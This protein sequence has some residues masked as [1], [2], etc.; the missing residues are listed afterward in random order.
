MCLLFFLESSRFFAILWINLC[1][2]WIQTVCC[3]RFV[4]NS[5]WSELDSSWIYQPE[6][7]FAV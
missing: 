5:Y 6:S 4:V 3:I 7:E 2:K 1:V